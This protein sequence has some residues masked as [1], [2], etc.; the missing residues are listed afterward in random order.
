MRYPRS[1][2]A[3]FYGVLAAMALAVAGYM[4]LA[5]AIFAL[6]GIGADR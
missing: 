3:C 1:Q 5:A 2:W 4:V 6:S